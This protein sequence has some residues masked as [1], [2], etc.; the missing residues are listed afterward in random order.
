[1]AQRMIGRVLL[2]EDEQTVS[3]MI[4]NEELGRRAFLSEA[5]VTTLHERL[6]QWLTSRKNSA[7]D[8]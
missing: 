6:G 8:E 1:M 7:R 5:E 4:R 3:L 2:S